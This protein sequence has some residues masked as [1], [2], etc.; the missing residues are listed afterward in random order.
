MLSVC[1]ILSVYYWSST[2]NLILYV[3]YTRWLIVDLLILPLNT[4]SDHLLLTVT[5]DR[6][7]PSATKSPSGTMVFKTSPPLTDIIIR[8][9]IKIKLPKKVCIIIQTKNV[10]YERKGYLWKQ[11]LLLI[12]NLQ[13]K[14]CTVEGI[15]KKIWQL[16]NLSDVCSYIIFLHST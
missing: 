5:P 3:L 1:G 11:K 8:L 2:S 13:K 7:L 12:E 4:Y 14:L 9:A 10:V 16:S 15:N 6:S